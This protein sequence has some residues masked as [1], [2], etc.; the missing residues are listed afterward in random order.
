MEVEDETPGNL[1][2][3]YPQPLELNSSFSLQENLEW[4]LLVYSVRTVAWE[5][6]GDQRVWLAEF[7]TDVEDDDIKQPV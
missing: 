2:L 1:L 6:F 4:I 5:N 3:N 7:A